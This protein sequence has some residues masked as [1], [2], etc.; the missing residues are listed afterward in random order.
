MSGFGFLP[1][2]LHK[3]QTNFAADGGGGFLERRERDR[4]VFGLEQPVERG[5]AG[6]HAAS[7]PGLGEAL[8][9]HAGFDLTGENALD[10]VG[11]TSS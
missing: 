3:F 5:A 10:G 4:T 2:A 8:F 11:A 1:F 6:P 9:L 7:H